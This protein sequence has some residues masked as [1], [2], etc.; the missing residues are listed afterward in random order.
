M[1]VL[2]STMKLEISKRPLDTILRDATEKTEKDYVNQKKTAPKRTFFNVPEIFDG[3]IEWKGC[4]TPAKNQGTCGSCWSFASTSTLADRFNIQSMGLMYVDLS[5][6]KLILC[7][8]GIGFNVEHPEDQKE[9]SLTKS[10]S[11][12]RSGSCYGDTLYEAWRYLFLVGTNTSKCMP[13]NINYGSF[14]EYQKIGSF[15]EPVKMPTCATVSGPIRDM[16]FD[17]KYDIHH[18]EEQGTPARFYRAFHFYSIAGTK[19]DGGSESNIRHEIF[20]W[21][22]VSTGMVVYPNFYTFDPKK[23]IYEAD[24]Q[25]ESIGG[26]AVELVGWGEDKGKKYW[27]VKNSWGEEWG[28]NGYFKML[29]GVNNC[30][31]EEN[32]ITGVPDFFYPLTYNSTIKFVWGESNESINKR[33]DMNTDYSLFGGGINPSTGY[34]RRA[35]VVY[36]WINLNR[37]V[38]LEDLPEWSK[39]VAGIDG[40]QK[41]RTKYQIDIRDKKNNIQYTQQSI[42]TVISILIFLIIILFISLFIFFKKIR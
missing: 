19:N 28:E 3:R 32:V 10:L 21:G 31:I 1:K 22:P 7:D 41:N 6:T 38:E 9:E 17:Y 11:S 23:E 14:K 13:Y 29:R 2:S 12:L 30:K 8:R 5:P 20:S 42:Y 16:C 4:L 40:G 35:M 37:P 15:T 25:S 24:E 33:L 27:I 39:W 18:A 26:H 36:P 34:T